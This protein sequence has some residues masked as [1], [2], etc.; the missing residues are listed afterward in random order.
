MRGATYSLVAPTISEGWSSTDGF[1]LRLCLSQSG[2]HVWGDFDFGI[3]TGTLRS[4]TLPQPPTNKLKLHW[5]DRE[6]GEGESTFGPENKMELQ[7][8]SENT[9]QGTMY[10]DSADTFEV[11]G[12]EIRNSDLSM[13]IRRWKDAYRILNQANYDMECSSRW[14]GGWT[15]EPEPERA[16]DSDTTDPQ[17]E[18]EEDDNEDEDKDKDEDE[19]DGEDDD[20]DE[21]DKEED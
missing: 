19:D 11:T 18:E 10:W 8:L 4:E 21:K 20:D 6:T 17:D 12:K 2:H 7:F 5:R 16:A 9:F 14:S 15:Q 1:Q 13:N 3:F